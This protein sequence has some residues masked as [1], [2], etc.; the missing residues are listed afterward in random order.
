M[1]LLCRGVVPC[2]CVGS[3]KQA[4]RRLCVRRPIRSQ[5]ARSGPVDHGQRQ[6]RNEGR[7]IQPRNRPIESKNNRIPHRIA[8][9]QFAFWCAAPCQPE[10]P[11]ALGRQQRP[12][13]GCG[14]CS[15]SIFNL[16]ADR[17]QFEGVCLSPACCVNPLCITRPPN[18]FL[19][20]FLL[21]R[22]RSSN[23]GAFRSRPTQPPSER[24]TTRRSL[25]F[26]L[27]L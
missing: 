18:R 15:A 11:G 1:R 4:K 3:G 24:D 14:G 10:S 19:R 22:F 6:R 26:A 2:A 20:R 8:R 13:S 23:Q 7:A 27:A 12:A 5:V 25:P 9:P 21:D 17:I 16:A